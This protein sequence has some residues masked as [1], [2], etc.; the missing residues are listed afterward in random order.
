[1]HPALDGPRGA[2]APGLSARAEVASALASAAA[3]QRVVDASDVPLPAGWTHPVL[4][5]FPDTGMHPVASAQWSLA[6]HGRWTDESNAV[7]GMLG[8]GEETIQ[9]AVES[10][11]AVLL[12]DP[13]AVVLVG[14]VYAEPVREA[15]RAEGLDGRVLTG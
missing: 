11:R 7:A 6:L 9:R 3:V 5:P 12:A 2:A 10:A 15:L 14:A 4:L 13:D 1:V 8:A